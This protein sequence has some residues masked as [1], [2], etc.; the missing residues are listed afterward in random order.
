MKKWILF[1]LSLVPVPLF[2]QTA[3]LPV[4]SC[5]QGAIQAKTSGSLS[6]NYLQ[7]VVPYCTVTV[8]LTGTQTIATTT[9]Q[10]PYTASAEGSFLIFAAIGQGYDIVLSA[11]FPPNIYTTPLTLTDIFSGGGGGG[12]GTPGGANT[13]TQFNN[14]GAFGGNA[15]LTTDGLGNTTQTGTATANALVSA[16]S[17]YLPG[18]ANATLSQTAPVLPAYDASN[19]TGTPVNM[20]VQYMAFEPMTIQAGQTSIEAI[21]A[22]I[23]ASSGSGLVSGITNKNGEMRMD[24]LQDDGSGNPGACLTCTSNNGAIIT[25]SYSA[26]NFIGAAHPYTPNLGSAYAYT[27]PTWTQ[28][29][30]SA[31]QTL[32]PGE[33]VYPVL[34]WWSPLTGP[35]GANLVLDSGTQTPTAPGITTAEYFTSASISGPWTKV[36]GTGI[37]YQ[38]IPFT[39]P[40]AALYDNVNVPIAAHG[41]SYGASVFSAIEGTAINANSQHEFAVSGISQG[42]SAGY[43]QAPWGTGVGGF[44]EYGSG[45]QAIQTNLP[46][47]GGDAALIQNVP[48]AVVLAEESLV[49]NGTTTGQGPLFECERHGYLYGSAAPGPCLGGSYGSAA[50]SNPEPV[51]SYSVATGN[52]V[53]YNT[54]GTATGYT[55]SGGGTVLTVAI[56]NIGA[57]FD[58]QDAAFTNFPATGVSGCGTSI[59]GLSLKV[60]S[61]TTSTI[62]FWTGGGYS[63]LTCSQTG[64]VTF[65]QIY[66]PGWSYVLSGLSTTEGA[67]MNCSTCTAP[68][69]TPVFVVSPVAASDNSFTVTSPTWTG[70]NASTT[71]DVGLVTAIRTAPVNPINLNPDQRP[72]L[73]Y[74]PSAIYAGGF[75][76]DWIDFMQNMGQTITA[77]PFF[78]GYPLVWDRGYTTPGNTYET[79][80]AW[81]DGGGNFNAKTSLSANGNPIDTAHVLLQGSTM[82]GIVVGN[83]GAPSAPTFVVTINGGFLTSAGAPYAYKVFANT[84]S[85]STPASAAVT[86]VGLTSTTTGRVGLRVTPLLGAI[87]YTWCGRTT[88]SY[89]QIATTTV[90][91]FIDDGSL[92]PSGACPSSDTSGGGITSNKFT[93]TGAGAGSYVKAD[94]TGYGTPSGAGNV[95]GPGSSTAGHIATF[96]D[97]T[98]LL[99]ADGGAAPVAPTST[100]AVG[101]T[102]CALHA[103]TTILA[104]TITSDGGS[105]GTTEI[106]NFSGGVPTTYYVGQKFGV[107]GASPGG[108]NGGPYIVTAVTATQITFTIG[109]AAAWTSGGTAYIW[110][111]NQSNDALAGNP[112]VFA[113]SYSVG[114]SY[115]TASN[116]L[117]CVS[118]QALI[119]SSSAP[120]ITLQLEKNAT[121]IYQ[122]LGAIVPTASTVARL[123]S[124]QWT[125]MGR[126]STSI[127][128]TMSGFTFSSSSTANTYSSTHQG[129]DTI[130]ANA[131]TV[132]PRLYFSANTAGNAVIQLAFGCSQN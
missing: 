58:G 95:V 113:N 57:G 114:A 79:Q 87:S 44:S 34:S 89:L 46:G 49:G 91:W 129:P 77:F 10:T 4:Q 68:G 116:K 81:L 22:H 36:S 130:S 104:I 84:S 69:A 42:S 88:G 98:G 107:T 119:S 123:G 1:L 78:G 33:I 30:V 40:A 8:Y 16:Q 43:F 18:P 96:A 131:E 65:P 24:L 90:P 71:A 31:P 85:G 27:S 111:G 26:L 117:T 9:P 112:Y 115:F 11:G 118:Q 38:A 51:F 106:L 93:V 108:I 105:S 61:A 99:L 72:T 39:P 20:T 47:V 62:V 86:S 29:P 76:G 75:P 32:T 121:I 67:T 37:W 6:S 59:N 73:A 122:S 82:P 64:T 45:V 21:Y 28:M 54:F 60:V 101:D 92:T 102:A 2:A 55:I 100:N 3:A 41:G 5:I 66:N 132:Q 17:S 12:G 35:L 110:C 97:G 63:D 128:T 70:A 74:I 83:L 14:N 7:G 126:S 13:N 48:Y 15:N 103:D 109:T 94:G 125:L 56:T 25:I 120:T 124:F 52:V 50:L 80:L 19:F 23:A 53:T 127:I